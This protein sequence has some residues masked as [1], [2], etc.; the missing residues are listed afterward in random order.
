MQSGINLY[1]T[2]IPSMSSNTES[3]TSIDTASVDLSV[4]RE[5]VSF[6]LLSSFYEDEMYDNESDSESRHRST[7]LDVSSCYSLIAEKNAEAMKI[8]VNRLLGSQK[9]YT[10]LEPKTTVSSV[11]EEYR[12]ELGYENVIPCRSGNVSTFVDESSY[13]PMKQACNSSFASE[14]LMHKSI[15]DNI[16][17]LPPCPR[18]SLS[19]AHPSSISLRRRKSSSSLVLSS[20]L[21]LKPRGTNHQYI[22][23]VK[24]KLRVNKRGPDVSKSMQEGKI[25]CSP[26]L[27]KSDHENV[28]HNIRRWSRFPRILCL[29]SI[30]MTALAFIFA[31]AYLSIKFFRNSGTGTYAIYIEGSTSLPWLSVKSKSCFQPLVIEVHSATNK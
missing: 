2:E 11:D 22:N 26:R 18:P 31:Y 27:I 14:S 15:R 16:K 10:N 30:T 28:L 9:S 19:L 1:H 21:I 3:V 23:R 12:G 25:Y 7:V 5:E 13:E 29:Y 8:E 4:C 17:H 20:P 6:D 24:S